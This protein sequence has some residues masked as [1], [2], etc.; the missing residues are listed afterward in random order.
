MHLWSNHWKLLTSLPAAHE[1]RRQQWSSSQGIVFKAVEPILAVPM[2]TFRQCKTQAIHIEII[3]NKEDDCYKRPEQKGWYR[4][5]CGRP[6]SY[7]L[8]QNCR[9]LRKRQARPADLQASRYRGYLITHPTRI[10]SHRPR[11]TI[12]CN[13]TSR[14]ESA[15]WTPPSRGS[16]A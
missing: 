12:A 5:H 16:R 4:V 8:V 15:A 1:A 10:C 13:R 14:R 6:G 9:R 2:S 11:C 3:T 7:S